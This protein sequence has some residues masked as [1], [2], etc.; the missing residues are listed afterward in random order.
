M[1]KSTT[2]LVKT[3]RFHFLISFTYDVYFSRCLQF[4]ELGLLAWYTFRSG[5]WLT[6]GMRKTSCSNIHVN[7]TS[8]L[9]FNYRNA[10]AWFLSSNQHLPIW[11]IN[12]NWLLN[13][14]VLVN[15]HIYFIPKGMMLC[16]L[17]RNVYIS[18][19][20]FNVNTRSL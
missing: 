4:N 16:W 8:A 3:L 9:V 11:V 12:P 20:K 13:S 15:A 6:I 17:L 5:S 7:F 19:S 1:V 2:I 18:P 10:Y 14:T